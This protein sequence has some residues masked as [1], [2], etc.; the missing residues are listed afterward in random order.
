MNRYNQIKNDILEEAV[1]YLEIT[2]P[3]KYN[4]GREEYLYEKDITNLRARGSD[5]N[6]LL[7]VDKKSYCKVVI[8][9]KCSNGKWN[10]TVYLS[11]QKYQDE[12]YNSMRKKVNHFYK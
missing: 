12:E 3:S 7:D 6:I 9:G 4:E 2:L 8:Y 1:R 10:A 11:C 5:K